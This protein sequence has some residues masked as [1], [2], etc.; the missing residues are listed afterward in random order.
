MRSVRRIR[1]VK[2]WQP[3]P[4]SKVGWM[5][6][7]CCVLK[8]SV[9]VVGDWRHADFEAAIGWLREHAQCE[10]FSSSIE[11]PSSMQRSDPTAIVLAQSRPGQFSAGEVERLHRASPLSRLVALCGV[12]CEG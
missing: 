2:C 9:W 11:A 4:N 5:G 6:N 7:E 8:P 3:S 10:F 12:W 1:R